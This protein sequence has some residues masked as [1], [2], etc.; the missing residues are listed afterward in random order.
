[1]QGEPPGWFRTED[2]NVLRWWDGQKWTGRVKLV[3]SGPSTPTVVGTLIALLIVGG[4]TYGLVDRYNERT[5]L[6]EELR[7]VTYAADP[8]YC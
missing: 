7:C 4:L 8:T 3:N 6:Y 1:M 5:L 2:P